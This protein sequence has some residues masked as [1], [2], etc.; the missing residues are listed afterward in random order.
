MIKS[1]EEIVK[2][3]KGHINYLTHEYLKKLIVPGVTTK[4]LDEEAEKFIRKHGEILHS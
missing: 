3:K 2:M 1:K 4:N